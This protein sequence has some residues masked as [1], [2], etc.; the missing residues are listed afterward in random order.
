MPTAPAN[1]AST[2]SGQN[3]ELYRTTL[4]E[5]AAGGSVLMGK[6]VDSA[7]QI[8]QAQEASLR[9]PKERELV[10]TA[11]NQLRR[12]E[13]NLY[14]AYPQALLRAFGGPQSGYKSQTL[15]VADVHFDQLELMD[16]AQVQISVTLARIRQYVMETAL[17][18]LSEL[19]SLICGLQGMGSVRAEHNPLRPDSYIG[20]LKEVVE[21]TEL[22]RS[23]QLLWFNAL[24]TVL[25][26]E[27]RAF[28]VTLNAQLRQQGVTTVGFAVPAGFG[29]HT[30]GAA[31][32][33]AA[34]PIAAA[35]TAPAA[36]VDVETAMQTQAAPLV[37][38]MVHVPPAF[39]SRARDPRLLTLDKL[40]RLLVGE[41]ATPSSGGNRVAEFSAQFDQQYEGNNL[42]VPQGPPSEFAETLPAA[43]EA[44]TEMKQVD[45]V[46]QS[47]QQRRTTESATAHPQAHSIEAQRQSLR[48]GARDVAQAISLEVVTLMVDNMARDPRLLEPVCQVI[49]G[50]EPALLRLA[51]VDPRF[52]TDKQHPARRLL[53]ELTHHSLA[54]ESATA[55]GFDRFMG[56]LQESLAP[57]LRASIESGEVFE[58]RLAILQKHWNVDSQAR[59]KYQDLAV[60]VLAHAEARNILAEKIAHKIEKHPDS[61]KVPAVVLDF[62]CGPWAQ[63]LAQA[64][65]K[66]GVGSPAAEKFE[67]LVPA[68][69]W[70]AHPELAR[71]NPAK[72]TRV[73]PR[74][75][76]TLREGLDTIQY[77]VTRTSNFLEALMAIHQQIFRANTVL[78]SAD[79]GV[80][81]TLPEMALPD[82]VRPVADG[83]PWI[84]PEEALASN[85]VELQEN[86]ADAD[87]ADAP[88][89]PELLPDLLPASDPQAMTESDFS[90]GSWVEMWTAG[91]WQ[92][93]QLTWASP[94]GTLFLFTGIFGT[95]QSM[96]RRSRDKLLATGRLRL[97][98]GQSVDQE[99]LDAVAQTAMRNS[100][101]SVL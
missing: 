23:M 74:L 81:A 73:V 79:A 99:A 34:A 53:H 95:T 10:A 3:Q 80:N 77:P 29:S 12:Q 27:L 83:N 101:D 6:M 14:A 91:Q 5:A 78:P 89:V 46:V 98:S 100:V 90:L 49:R 94:H 48:Q 92:R 24:T 47:L 42:G 76:T 96:T 67:A 51:L 36:A 62:L 39:Q 35:P 75:L 57:L 2:S 56:E 84:A 70:S 64:R 7:R 8:L 44:L 33:S 19:N 72:L 15:S 21:Q 45:R 20:A 68:L 9:D 87:P 32:P 71:T 43:V 86:P 82:R 58:A 4:Q 52:F 40:R 38:E 55:A 88:L 18:S 11:A 1:P 26:P 93:T 28:Y 97:V 17:V 25:G 50:L 85:F 30:G 65:I 66:Q 69:L 60:D 31:L 16:E 61:A 13:Q 41:L 59:S 37:D 22:P 63:V 54:F